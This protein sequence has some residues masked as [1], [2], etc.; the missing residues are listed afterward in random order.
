LSEEQA[1]ALVVEHGPAFIRGAFELVLGSLKAVP[2][3]IEAF[4][5]DAGMGW[6]E[7]DTGVFHGRERCF[8][9]G[10]GVGQALAWVPAHAVVQAKLEAGGH[11]AGAGG[12]QRASSVLVAQAFSGSNFFDV[13][14]RRRSIDTARK[15]AQRTGVGERVT[16]DFATAKESPGKG[17]ELVAVFD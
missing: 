6:H 7:R 4:H 11:V 10:Y 13:N 3:V 1:F 15:S 9:P 5:D 14:R 8:R 16:F 2:R 12:G 17:C